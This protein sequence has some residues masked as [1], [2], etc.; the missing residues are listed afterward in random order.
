MEPED[1][2]P[3]C[4]GRDGDGD[5]AVKAAEAAQR[6]VECIRPGLENRQSIKQKQAE[7]AS[8]RKRGEQVVWNCGGCL[9]VGAARTSQCG[10]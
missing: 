8:I 9:M 2:E 6:G 10:I 5:L 3:L 1:G 4:R 7:E